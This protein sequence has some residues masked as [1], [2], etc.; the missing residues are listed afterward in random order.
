[1]SL[2]AAGRTTGLVTDSGDGVSHTVPV[3]DGYSIPHAIFRMD[4]AGR[5]LTTYVQKL[6]QEVAGEN[7]TS[8]SELDVVK[9]IKETL[10][11]VSGTA[12]A[13]ATNTTE[14]ESSSTHDKNYTMPDKRVINV[15][16]RVR[17]GGPELLFN[18]ALDGLTCDGLQAITN[19]SIMESDVDVRK[20]LCKNIILSGGSTMFEGIQDRLKHELEAL[21]PSGSD[22][23]IVAEPTRKFSVWRGASTLSS[24]SS[25]DES[26]V[27]KADYEEHGFQVLH[28]KC[29]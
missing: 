7:L 2:Y 10:C 3:F 27:S 1:M 22:V 6:M 12:E 9:N 14:A 21:L 25:F 8:S 5:R 24:L 28:R 4:I 19:R 16:G 17:F 23:R 20:D 18:P 11:F 13:Y 26:W 15:P 29:S